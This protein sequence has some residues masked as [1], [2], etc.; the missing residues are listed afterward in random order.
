M[1]TEEKK[2][3][4][5]CYSI[6]NAKHESEAL[7]KQRTNYPQDGNCLALY[8]LLEEF[9]TTNKQPA[10]NR[11]L[12]QKNLREEIR[13]KADLSLCSADF[14]II[15]LPPVSQKLTAYMLYVGDLEK[16]FL[17][18]FGP[19]RLKK[20]VDKLTKETNFIGLDVTNNGIGYEK[21]IKSAQPQDNSI[22]KEIF[23]KIYT[24]LYEEIRIC[25]GEDHARSIISSTYQKII[26]KYDYSITSYIFD[27]VPTGILD[28]EKLMFMSR[29]N[30]EK[31]V[32]QRT[33]E[34]EETKI[35]LEEKVAARTIE[36]RDAKSRVE[37]I[38]TSIGD[39]VFA[40]DLSGNIIL[41]N[42][43]A[44]ELS[45]VKF[46][47]AVGKH[48]TLIFRFISEEQPNVP[49]GP[50]VENVISSG[51]KQNL[52][53]HTQIVQKN[54]TKITIS[55]SAAPIVGVDGKIIGCVVVF[56]DFSR[57][58]ELEKAKDTFLSIAAHQLRTP[59]GSMRW[60]LEMLL[61]EDVGS[62][63]PEVKKVIT[64]IYENDKR[65]I[66]LVNDLL[67]VSRIDQK[68]VAFEP[69]L[70]DIIGLTRNIIKEVDG[71][72]KKRSIKIDFIFDIRHAFEITIDKK[73]YIEAIENLL[74]NA[75]KYSQFGGQVTIAI[76]RMANR[77][78][79][80][81][82]TDSGIGIPEKD[83]GNIFAKFFRAENAIKSET[84]GTGLGLYVVKSY[85]EDMGGQIS[86]TSTENK[87]TTFKVL[88]P[89]R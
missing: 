9:I 12:N 26:Q 33:A 14:R 87:G 81:T 30:L 43:I 53:A 83:K 82:I 68:R 35:H 50:F 40:V 5:F 7:K 20:I 39:A 85:I 64:Q 28:Y 76:D 15:F 21:L 13:N 69:I 67:N 63:D 54:G 31:L 6:I 66:N 37:T 41:M 77:M 74:S 24:A 86:Y 61:A 45:G 80:I 29:E 4:D 49:Y 60:N 51:K 48:Y 71:L 72:A 52:A 58:R 47:D 19:K 89:D 25:V 38:L 46:T 42:S 62:L 78:V 44:E 8:Y 16:H 34:L 65:L 2:I 84:E 10:V 32:Q 23:N 73:R 70:T 18:N 17:N 1:N 27:I 75:I 88:I 22:Y 55:D 57:E 56:R 3:I 11:E 59:L 36:L 79:Q